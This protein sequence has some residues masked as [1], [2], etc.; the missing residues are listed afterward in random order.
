VGVG[1]GET[2]TSDVVTFVFMGRLIGWKS[3]DLLLK[4]FASARK[5]A[6]CGSDPR[7][8]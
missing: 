3:V 1:R 2:V 7:R 8:R 6:R 4:A 5:G